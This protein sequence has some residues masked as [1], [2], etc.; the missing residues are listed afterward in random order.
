MKEKI[1]MAFI[2]ISSLFLCSCEKNDKDFLS[3]PDNKLEAHT[4]DRCA[5]HSKNTPSPKREW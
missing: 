5:L 2:V 1:M 3:P 4:Y